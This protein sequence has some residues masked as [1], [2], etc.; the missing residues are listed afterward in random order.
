MRAGVDDYVSAYHRR[1][2]VV[3][4]PIDT[5]HI[6]RYIDKGLPLMWTCFV[7]KLGEQ[8]VNSHTKARASVT[9][10]AA[11]KTQLD[12]DDKAREEKEPTARGPDNGHMR[13]IIG[14]NATTNE[15]AIS[16]SWGE[17]MAERWMTVKQANDITAGDLEYIQW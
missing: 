8:E 17:R 3:T 1:I 4:D 9:D 10:W 14:Y 15:I 2:E 5:D 16:D 7:T 13:M 6:A 12:T 11:Y